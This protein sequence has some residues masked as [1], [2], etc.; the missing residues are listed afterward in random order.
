MH[1]S[2][3]PSAPQRQGFA[4]TALSCAVAMLCPL[5]HA[6]DVGTPATSSTLPTLTITA[7]ADRQNRASISGLGDTPAWQA[8]VQANSFS[9][10]ALQNAQVSRLADL[11]KLDASI[12]DNYNA[13]GYWD[14]LSIR[15]YTL[16][17]TYNWRREGLPINGETRIALD[18]KSAVEI[19]KGTSGMQAG[20]SSPGGLV[21]LLVKR[22][23]GHVRSVTFSV[24][25]S[26]DVLGAVDLGERFGPQNSFGLRINAAAERLSSHV[27]QT[28]GHRQL[29]ALAGDWV[30]APGSKFEAEIEHSIYSQPSAPGFSLLGDKLPSAKD[31]APGINLNR[32]P[33]TQPVVFRG[34]TATLRWTQALSADWQGSL[35]YGE[36]RL[37]TD[38]RAAFP[39]G[40]SA[41]NDYTRFCSDGSF[42]LDD[43]RSNNERRTSR[44]LLAKAD[45]QLRAIGMRHDLS[46]SVLRNLQ[47]TRLGN[48][49]FNYA[50][51]GDISGSF[52][53]VP[54]ASDP[55]YAAL[56]RQEQSTEFSAQDALA[57]NE[58]TRAWFGLR[59]TRLRRALTPTDGSAGSSLNSHVNTPWVA[60]GHTIA[61]QTQAYV[62]W[63]EGIE[64]ASVPYFNS[65][66]YPN[67]GAPLPTLKSRQTEVGVKG[68]ALMA[69]WNSQWGVDVFRINR[70]QSADVNG[71]YVIDGSARHQGIEASW[72]GRHGAWGLLGSA[73]VL[74][75]KR[76]GSAQTGVNGQSPINVPDSAIKASGSYSFSAPL[77]LVAQLD[78]IHEG[79]RWVDAANTTRLPSWTRTDLSLRHTQSSD[80]ETV[81]W[82]LGVSNL[83]DV[84]AWRESSTS[85]GH[86]YLFP[87]MPRTVTASAQLDF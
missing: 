26:G 80:G 64:L 53:D 51:P 25:D 38:D 84:R 45:G 73:M 43:Y 16:S 70:P 55:T 46:F 87:M 29:L 31:I 63:G 15:G 4:P 36:Q 24:Q 75:A 82:R 34:D 27:D 40:C 47:A 59:H 21:N 13:V 1:R 58:S 7:P 22:P 68:Q 66:A 81:T 42:D 54:S 67:A 72:Q 6:Q 74:D 71:A 35:T 62:S 10:A 77:P 78:L 41:S 52:A 39:Y 76:R 3:H 60:L 79:R 37:S 49:A 85:G 5:A 11:T 30:P 86:I 33:W 65:P 17:N 2:S 32:Q 56:T 14:A 48:Y 44:S 20:V 28:R 19:F 8:P 61:P 83:F 57:F 50:G 18:N 12:S 9:Q 69:G 23:E